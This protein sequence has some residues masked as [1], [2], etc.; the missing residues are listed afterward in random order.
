MPTS[1]TR[2]REV[3]PGIITFST[4]FYRF[5]PFGYRQ[6]VAVGNRAT[7][8]RLGDGRILLLNPVQIEPSVRS[9]LMELG[10]VDLVAADLGHHMYIK[11]YLEVWPNARTIGVS[12][13]ESKR[14]DIKWDYIYTDWRSSPEDEF[15]FANDFE[16]VLFEG[17]ITYC[18]AWYHKPTKT[19][20]QSDLMMNLPSTE[21]YHPSSS[22]QGLF[23]KEFAKR[24]HPRSVWA[25]RLVYYIATVD[26]LLMRRDAKKVADWDFDCI[27]VCHG[28]VIENH[29][30]LAWSNLYAWYLEGSPYPTLSKRL[31]GPVMRVARWVFLM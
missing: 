25:K 6:F 28:D 26:Y 19:L 7:A 24:A 15:D 4:P 31:M 5:A 20:I 14:K 16:T 27:I 2:I 30:K 17:F 22:A 8:I 1:G 10:G 21:Q 9:K 13:L 18:V 11:D 12:G 23:S 3:T 29:G